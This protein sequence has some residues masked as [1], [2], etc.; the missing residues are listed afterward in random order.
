MKRG[1]KW[2]ILVGS[3]IIYLFDALEIAVLSFALPAISAELK[4]TPI[5]GGLL[6]TATLLG[7]GCSSIITGWVA[8]NRGRRIA[9]IGSMVVFVA[10]TSALFVVPNYGVFVALR[11]L[12]GIGLGGVWSVLSTYIVETWPAEQRGRAVAFV[13]AAY[14]LGGAGAALIAG[15]FMPDWR[16]LFLVTG[17]SA[18]LPLLMVV[19]FFPE[20]KA[21]LAERAQQEVARNVTA[22][23]LF[24]GSYRRRTIIATLVAVCA[25][26]GFYGASTWMPSY[27]SSERCLDPRQ[28]SL[29]M[30]ILN[31][32]MFAGYIVFGW[33]ADKIGRRNAIMLSL[34]GT[35]FLMPLYG[36]V[37]NQ[38]ALLWMGPL[39]AFFMTFAGLFGSYLGELYPTR[40][41]TTG[42]GFCFNI[43]RGVAAFAPLAMGGI[44]A[45]W[46]FSSGLILSGAVFLVGGAL[47]LFLPHTHR[48]ASTDDSVSPS[49]LQ[50]EPV[51]NA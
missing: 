7:M 33:I 36:L 19:F 39:Y 14:P 16:L 1:T 37:T 18:L 48:G 40:I 8:D 29:F 35:G 46:G 3:F 27:L 50:K 17:L 32:G 2:F 34:T 42:A 45:A 47:M 23:E 25:F 9:L 13:L 21:W 24:T 6:A 44:A 41:R 49:Y 31:L 38:A 11:F 22:K 51:N 5:A 20:S 4:L 12:A 28:V 10:L 30:T 26:V 15:A 43:G